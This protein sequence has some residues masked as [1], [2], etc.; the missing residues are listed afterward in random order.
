MKSPA[1]AFQDVNF[2]YNDDIVLDDITFE[3]EEGDYV[4]ILGP[5]G[6]GKTTLLNILFG[7]LEPRTGSVSIFGKP[8]SRQ[9]LKRIGYVPQTVSQDDW[10]FPATVEEI[11]SSGCVA[12][13]GLFHRMGRDHH[14]GVEEAL[15]LA[16]IAPLRK[17]LIG[18]LSGGQRQ[19]V[20]IARALAG[21]P[22]VLVLDEPTVG[23]DVSVQETFYAF[24]KRLNEEQGMTIIFVSHDI[25]VISHEA[26][27]VLCVNKKL[28]CHVPA[29]DAIKSDVL[30]KMYGE[31]GKYI[32]HGH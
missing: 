21:N 14:T 3:I 4:G 23:V 28:V 20:F 17:R 24:L 18:Q 27:N 1:I 9:S 6:S 32:L 12:S 11:V 31:K 8:V 10:S 15:A 25:D 2:F 16:E 22:D 7:L 19:R 5:N 13:Q 30:E 29:K 26:K